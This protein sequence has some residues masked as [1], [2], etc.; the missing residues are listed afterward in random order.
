M[1][2]THDNNEEFNASNYWRDVIAN[3]DGSYEEYKTLRDLIIADGEWEQWFQKVRPY[4]CMKEFMYDYDDLV[5]YLDHLHEQ[6]LDLED[7]EFCKA[8]VNKRLYSKWKN[9]E[10]NNGLNED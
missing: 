7:Y 8:L 2:T 10:I 4:D 1:T 9:D 3:L 6:A 5:E